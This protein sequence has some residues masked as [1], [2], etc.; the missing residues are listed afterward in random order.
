MGI[1]FPEFLGFRG[2]VVRRHELDDGVADDGRY[3]AENGEL[4]SDSGPLLLF[5]LHL[6]RFDGVRRERAQ[7]EGARTDPNEGAAELADKDMPVVRTSIES[8]PFG[9]KTLSAD[10]CCAETSAPLTIMTRTLL[11]TPFVFHDPLAFGYLPVP[12]QRS[13]MTISSSGFFSAASPGLPSDIRAASEPRS[14][15][16]GELRESP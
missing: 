16:P 1:S 5:D 6:E 7:T 15:L 10:T 13:Y 8:N 12:F 2:L 4:S 14:S 3:D 11:A 9:V